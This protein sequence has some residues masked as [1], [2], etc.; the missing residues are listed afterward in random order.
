M[1]SLSVGRLVHPRE[2][3]GPCPRAPL[4]TIGAMP[5]VAFV[6]VPAPGPRRCASW[7]RR[8]ATS[9][10]CRRSPARCTWGASPSRA[11]TASTCCSTLAAMSRPRAPAA[12]PDDAILARTVLL[13]AE[14]PP[15]DSRDP[16]LDVLRPRGSGVRHRP[17]GGG[18]RSRGS[19]S[20]RASS[21][22]ATRDATTTSI[23]DADAR[24]T[25]LFLGAHTPRRTRY[26]DRGAPVSWR[27]ELRRAH[28]RARAR[29]GR[30][31]VVAGRR[32]GRCWRRQGRHQPPRRRGHAAR[33]ARGCSTPSMPAP[34]S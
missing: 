8:W 3:T 28:R 1:R 7:R 26:L 6:H 34:W 21:A 25:S 33:V 11:R 27:V 10:D 4:A 31:A 19:A 5:E 16:H 12:L 14:P 22:P 24:S 17:A 20:A 13:C 2:A 29:R 30:A 15:T 9:S 18:R 23:P 32:R